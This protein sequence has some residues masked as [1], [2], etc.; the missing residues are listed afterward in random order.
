MATPEPN[1]Q[2]STVVQTIL[3]YNHHAVKMYGEADVILSF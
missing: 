1:Y 2:P 3:V